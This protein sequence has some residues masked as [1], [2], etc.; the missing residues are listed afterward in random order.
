M[1]REIQ[2]DAPMVIRNQEITFPVNRISLMK[3]ERINGVLVY[4]EVFGQNLEG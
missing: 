4:T 2:H 1:G 3:S